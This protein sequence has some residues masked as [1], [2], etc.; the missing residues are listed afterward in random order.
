MAAAI[1]AS[2]P[3]FS[4]T[5]VNVAKKNAVYKV[6]PAIPHRT[7][8]RRLLCSFLFMAPQEDEFR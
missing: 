5:E 4:K 8:C 7:I 1:W 6:A 3:N 2:H